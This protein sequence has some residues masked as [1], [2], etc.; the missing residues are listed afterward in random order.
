MGLDGMVLLAFLLAFPANEIMLPV[1]A[2]G[3]L[4]TSTMLE[5]EADR[6]GQVLTAHGWSW[7][8]AVCATV[9]IARIA[10]A[11]AHF[12][13][14]FIITYLRSLFRMLFQHFKIVMLTVSVTTRLDIL[15]S[16]NN[17]LGD[18]DFR[19]HKR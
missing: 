19:R 3:Y 7:Q 13:Q 17:T 15:V 4:S 5:V 18:R 9:L 6:L 14:C 10:A 16:G 8:T 12:F 11:F 2:M 1:L